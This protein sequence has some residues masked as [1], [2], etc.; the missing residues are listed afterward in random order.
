MRPSN[1]V[2]LFCILFAFWIAAVGGCSHPASEAAPVTLELIS[3]D[4]AAG[5]DIPKSLTCDGG[6]LSPALEWKAPPAG[7]QSFVLIADDPDAPVG[8]WVHWVIF[9]LPPDMRSLPRNLP[10]SGQFADGSRQGSNDFD[11]IG[12]GGPCPPSGK[13]HRY[14]FKLYALDTNL[15]LNPGASKKEVER[16]VDGHILARGETMGRYAR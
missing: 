16:A 2:S 3:T 8:A 1:R 13:S 14:F 9:D 7:T 11:K 12:Y 6:D 5:G 10:K 15:K 4:F